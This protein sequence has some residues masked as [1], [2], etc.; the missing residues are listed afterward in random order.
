CLS[1][2]P[3]P[4]H[5]AP[6]EPVEREVTFAGAG[7]TSLAGTLLPPEANVHKR[8]PAL[9]LVAGSGPTDRDGN[10]RPAI[11]TDLLKQF[12]TALAKRGI[13]TLRYD[14]RGMHA[15]RAQLPKEVAQYG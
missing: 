15:N 11:V 9:V 2:L 4:T 12:A 3:L 13:A 7:G 6:A 8:V 1:L 10:Q 14:K 5:A